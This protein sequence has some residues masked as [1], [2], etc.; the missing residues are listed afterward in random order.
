V[1]S[2]KTN[3][4]ALRLR[5]NDISAFNTLYWDYHGPVYANALKLTRD[6]SIAEDIVQ[7]V[8]VTLWE[9]RH[10]IDPKQDV[11]GWLFVVS[12]NKAKT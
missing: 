11:A 4:L 9:K 2:R 6:S 5:N 8:F 1:K 7:E 12:H 3:D 10:T